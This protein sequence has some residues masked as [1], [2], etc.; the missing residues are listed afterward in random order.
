MVRENLDEVPHYELAAPYTM[1]WYRP[2]DQE[3][4]LEIHERA[5]KYTT[6]TPGLFEQQFGTDAEA[7]GLRQCYLCDPDG[8]PIGTATAWFGD[9]YAGGPWGRV[10]WVAIVPERQGRG[11]SKPLL[12]RVCLRLRELGHGRAYLTTQTV[13]TAAINLYLKFGFVPEMRD[14]ADVR[15]WRLVR[16]NV[17]FRGRRE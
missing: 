13:R 1:R 4:W 5:D 12:S 3:A 8:T 6:V 9:D 14:E 11:L 17:H 2:G 15:A 7:L 16:E 10:H